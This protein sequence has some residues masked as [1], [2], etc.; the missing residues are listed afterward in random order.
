MNTYLFLLSLFI[1]VVGPLVAI[2]Y[3]K[4]ILTTVLQSLCNADGS[5]ESGF[6]APICWPFLALSFR[7]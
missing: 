3:L 1:A 5:A 2:N 7:C 4:P 6:V